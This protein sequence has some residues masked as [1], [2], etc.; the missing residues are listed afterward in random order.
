MAEDNRELPREV[1][2]SVFVLCACFTI[3]IGV[4]CVFCYFMQYVCPYS[5]GECAIAAW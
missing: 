1:R 5:K 3:G 2:V 4:L